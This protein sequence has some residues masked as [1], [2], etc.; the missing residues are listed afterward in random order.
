MLVTA[1]FT[2]RPQAQ[3]QRQAQELQQR[4]MM[5]AQIIARANAEQQGGAAGA[6]GL[7]G[8][9]LPPAHAGSSAAMM[10]G[11]D[12][13][14]RAAAAHAAATQAAAGISA[15]TAAL[16][17]ATVGSAGSPVAGQLLPLSP[18]GTPM[19]GGAALPAYTVAS[20]HMSPASSPHL[21]GT[22]ASMMMMTGGSALG[23]VGSPP[24]ALSP[25]TWQME[26]VGAMS[27]PM[28]ASPM[29]RAMAVSGGGAATAASTGHPVA[30]AVFAAP[31]RD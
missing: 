1:P 10:V 26:P 8:L 14:S 31:A 24:L 27:M 13:A 28:S 12:G 6:A 15:S 23:A 21:G 16:M 7:P 3:L 19:M 18:G 30:G 4:L 5:E 11:L 20:P 25:R 29:R 17:Q 9:L 2:L 22:A